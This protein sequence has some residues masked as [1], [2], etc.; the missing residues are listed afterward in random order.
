MGTYVIELFNEFI[1]LISISY[2]N[3][4]APKYNC[5][6]YMK[7]I[8]AINSNFQMEELNKVK[9]IITRV[10]TLYYLLVLAR[11]YLPNIPDQTNQY[12]KQMH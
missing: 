8:L 9:K 7:Y 11:G 12:K 2:T 4:N 1:G 5:D 10:P 6:E 3:G